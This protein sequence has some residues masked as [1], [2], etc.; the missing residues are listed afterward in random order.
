GDGQFFWQNDDAQFVHGSFFVAAFRVLEFFNPVENLA[1]IS[2]RINGQLVADVDSQNAREIAPEHGRFAIE[3][4]LALFDELAKWDDFFFRAWIDSADNRRESLLLKLDDHWT[5]HE[6]RGR[7]DMR[8]VVDLAFNLAPIAHHVIAS[9][10]NVRVEVDDLLPQL[11][12][13]PG[14]HRD[15]ENQNRNPKRNAD[16]RDQRDDRNEGAFRF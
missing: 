6:R 16:D 14:H 4:E 11:A 13:E 8:R 12:I 15:D 3:I 5:L 10:E 1:E 2:R 7:D 9:D